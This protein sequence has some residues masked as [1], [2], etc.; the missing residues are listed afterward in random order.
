MSVNLK[1]K[2]S[3]IYKEKSLTLAKLLAKSLT[4]IFVSGLV[5]AN[6][7][8]Q[9]SCPTDKGYIYDFNNDTCSR[10]EEQDALHL[11]PGASAIV[12][13]Y[14]GKC[15][16]ISNGSNREFFVPVGQQGDVT[17][18]GRAENGWFDFMKYCTVDTAQSN[19]ATNYL[20]T[21]TD[22][23]CKS[24]CNTKFSTGSGAPNT[25]ITQSQ[26][27]SYTNTYSSNNITN[28]SAAELCANAYYKFTKPTPDPVSGTWS[29]TCSDYGNDS[30]TCKA[31]LP[32]DGVCATN[33]P[34]FAITSPP[35]SSAL[36]Q[37]GE[38]VAGG[39]TFSPT[40][41]NSGFINYSCQGKNGG[42]TTAC[43]SVPAIIN[44]ACLPFNSSTTLPYTYPPNQSQACLVA[45]SASAAGGT[46]TAPQVNG[47][48]FVWDCIGSP[49]GGTSTTQSNGSPGCWAPR[50]V[51]CGS[52]ASATSPFATAPTSGL[53]D[54][55]SV[56][57]VDHSIPT[58]FRWNCPNYNP[59]LYGGQYE[60]HA[61]GGLPGIWTLQS[62]GSCNPGPYC[63]ASCTASDV[64]YCAK[65]AIHNLDCDPAAVPNT[66]TTTTVSS[67][68]YVC[69]CTAPM[70]D[71]TYSLLSSA[72]YKN[73]D[74]SALSCDPYTGWY[75]CM[76]TVIQGGDYP[77]YGGNTSGTP[78]CGV[79][80]VSEF[81]NLVILNTIPPPPPSN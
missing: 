36:C 71:S 50:V 6:T 59:A 35:L 21:C 29:W 27:S 42:A 17:A 49:N 31:L 5:Y 69:V 16:L 12:K 20:L 7:S 60:C 43:P 63:G 15:H 78:S 65:D 34:A 3:S 30:E 2:K 56:P 23:P 55:G 37:N 54:D 9:D 52:A 76:Q 72:Y 46:S 41:Q 74:G 11:L 66:T 73:W 51:G 28:A 67:A 19:L 39:M 53:C 58:Q 38:S 77:G 26:M 13:D 64:Y 44:G 81:N 14:Q 1:I 79:I 33:V 80:T 48:Y 61:P 57:Y 45:S 47:A 25:L 18:N 10:R 4:F 32:V 40:S 68:G 70:V 75:K 8:V 62:R 22:S 24:L